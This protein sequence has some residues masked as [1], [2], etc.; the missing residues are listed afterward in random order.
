MGVRLYTWGAM[1]GAF[2]LIFAYDQYDK[3]TNYVEANGQIRAVFQTCYLKGK[4][5]GKK[6]VTDQIECTVAEAM[7]K[8]HPLYKNWNLKREVKLTVGFKSP[9]DGQAHVSEITPIWHEKD[10]VPKVGD[11]YKVLASK[12]VADRARS[13]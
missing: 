5:D 13:L 3:A 2:G 1:A 6:Y 12:S 10:K 7:Q 4:L 9:V 8:N 11:Q